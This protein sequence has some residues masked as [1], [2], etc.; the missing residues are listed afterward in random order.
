MSAT[1]TKT[2]HGTYVIKTADY[3]RF[4][5][6]NM[7]AALDFCRLLGFRPILAINI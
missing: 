5:K 1:I 7:R 6:P 3:C 4:E 2:T